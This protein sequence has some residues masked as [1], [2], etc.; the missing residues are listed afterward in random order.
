MSQ[1][2]SLFMCGVC[3]ILTLQKVDLRFHFHP[4]RDR[5]LKRTT[6]RTQSSKSS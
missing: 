1:R 6:D 5:H 2:S 4:C 3:A